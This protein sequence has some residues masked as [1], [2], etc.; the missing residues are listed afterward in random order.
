M[1]GAVPVH[2]IR[3]GGRA[4]GAMQRA[5]PAYHLDTGGLNALGNELCQEFAGLSKLNRFR[6]T[7]ARCGRHKTGSCLV[8]VDVSQQFK[9]I[10]KAMVRRGVRRLGRRVAARWR[11]R[12][13]VESVDSRGKVVYA[14]A[15]R[16]IRRRGF[17]SWSFGSDQD[18]IEQLVE[19]TAGHQLSRLGKHY[20]LR[21]TGVP[22]GSSIS[23]IKASVALSDKEVDAYKD[24]ERAWRRGFVMEGQDPR[25]R[26]AGSGLLMTLPFSVVNYVGAV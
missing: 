1:Q 17:A 19:W 26:I 5:D 12:A 11:C 2:T 21:T 18:D 6:C 7:C 22:M 14:L 8:R 4:L 16:A 23:P 3:R 20:L 13:V 15:R 24:K 25:E 10:S 9:R